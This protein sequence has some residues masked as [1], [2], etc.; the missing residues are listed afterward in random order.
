MCFICINMIASHLRSIKGKK[1]S[2][3]EDEYQ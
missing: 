2:E 1:K 3:K